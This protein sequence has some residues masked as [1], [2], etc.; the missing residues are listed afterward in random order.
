ML[1]TDAALR[2]QGVRIA[3]PVQEA[4]G[5]KTLGIVPDSRIVIG[6]AQV[7]QHPGSLLET[8]T[9]PFEFFQRPTAD[10]RKERI[11]TPYFLHEGFNESSA[12]ACKRPFQFG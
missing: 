5:L 3:L 6:A 11:K 7:E 4:F 10:H 9:A 1:D 12:P 8:M 2:N